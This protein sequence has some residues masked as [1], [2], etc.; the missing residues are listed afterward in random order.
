MVTRFK[1]Q[2]SHKAHDLLFKTVHS[3]S[4]IYN[5]S[6]EDPRIDRELLD[7]DRN[8]RVV[9]LTSAGCNT[10][11]YLVD[12]PK[13]IHAIDVNP[14]QNALLQ[15]KLGLIERGN[16]DD[17]FAMFGRG[18]HPNYRQIYQEIRPSLSD[19]S[20]E[21]W[22]AKIRY[23]DKNSK[24]QSFYYYGTSG[25]F[26][27][28]MSRYLMKKP[29]I[30][31]E[32]LNLLD[33]RSLEEQA[34]I[35]ERLEPKL[36]GKYVSWLVRQPFT[37]SLLGVPRPQ[38]RLITEQYPGELLGYLGD[39]IKHVSTS[40]LIEDNYFWRVYLTGSYTE[41]CC[42]NYLKQENF[43]ILRKN[44]SRVHVH[45]AT[46]TNFL[47]NNPGEYTHFILLD[48]QDWLAQHDPEALE[49]EWKLILQNSRPGS[50]ILMR[51]AAMQV[52]FIP[53]S[54]KAALRFFPDLTDRLHLRD[55]V[56]TYG[57]LHFAEVT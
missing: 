8:S 26:A 45:N 2:I 32:I 31:T 16:F 5:A 39:K 54:A 12:S 49:E 28:L 18:A 56:G 24:K 38:I 21:F 37:M 51:S 55:R 48:H 30:R 23:F 29:Q 52:D 4:L 6:W 25:L 34:A 1:R 10:L 57:S 14:R 22:D 11:D 46:I 41:T 15:L 44:K 20:I 47:K 3:R 35:Y 40:V 13:E 36:W 7:L 27:W 43:Q 42:P 17:L 9:M 53:E 33:S 50:K 19:Q